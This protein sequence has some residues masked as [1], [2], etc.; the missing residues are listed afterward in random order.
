MFGW[1]K[2]LRRT[3]A[4]APPARRRS[5][6][7]MMVP[8]VPASSAPLPY[9]VGERVS[10]VHAP[11]EFQDPNAVAA[12]R[13]SDGVL[14]GHLEGP[15]AQIVLGRIAES[16]KYRA[17]IARADRSMDARTPPNILLRVEFQGI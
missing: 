15:L 5:T 13:K 6:T 9:K 3:K 7:Q 11:K 17:K 16:G 14:I 1:L 8:L 10:L 2:R 4:E 12:L